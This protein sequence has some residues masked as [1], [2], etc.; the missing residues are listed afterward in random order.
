MFAMPRIHI[1]TATFEPGVHPHRKLDS[2]YTRQYSTDE[3][4][5][6]EEP[7]QRINPATQ[8]SNHYIQQDD[9]D[10]FLTTEL[11]EFFGRRFI[12]HQTALNCVVID[13]VFFHQ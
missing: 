6:A 8:T 10:I 5:G 3:S 11:R 1:V 12:A 9:V 2:E 13:A 4:P 7:S